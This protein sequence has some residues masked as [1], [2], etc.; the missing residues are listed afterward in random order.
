MLKWNLWITDWNAYRNRFHKINV[1]IG[2][3]FL[4]LNTKC[5][6]C[7]NH[8]TVTSCH[9]LRKPPRGRRQNSLFI[10]SA[11]CTSNYNNHLLSL[12][13]REKATKEQHLNV[14]VANSSADQLVWK[15]FTFYL[16]TW[17]AEM[18]QLVV[19]AANKIYMYALS[20]LGS[21][22]CRWIINRHE[23]KTLHT[24]VLRLAAGWEDLHRFNTHRTVEGQCVTKI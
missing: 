11:G 20:Q 24:V 10:R 16:H 19:E 8:A 14:V 21:P 18:L 13:M 23:W 17:L 2:A 12:C 7:V 3:F 9:Q 5:L 6:H 4:F 15:T 1:N 22:S